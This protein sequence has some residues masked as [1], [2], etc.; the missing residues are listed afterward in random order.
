MDD[1]QETM[2]DEGSGFTHI[3][4][5]PVSHGWEEKGSLCVLS[6]KIKKEC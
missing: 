6:Q 1:K 5:F 4:Y 2:V 3:F